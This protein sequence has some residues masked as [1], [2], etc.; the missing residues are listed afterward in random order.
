MWCL[1]FLTKLQIY[2]FE[3]ICGTQFINYVCGMNNAWIVNNVTLYINDNKVSKRFHYLIS[4]VP[5]VYYFNTTAV[6]NIFTTYVV[7]R[8]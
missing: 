5:I 2:N 6:N 8:F 3:T 4:N 7:L 1:M